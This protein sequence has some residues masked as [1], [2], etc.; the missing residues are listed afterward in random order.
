MRGEG[1]NPAPYNKAFVAP[2]LWQ[3]EAQGSKVLTPEGLD[4]WGH[5][6]DV[7]EAFFPVD[8]AEVEACDLASADQVGHPRG[9]GS[10]GHGFIYDPRTDGRAHRRL[11]LEG[12]AQLLGLLPDGGSGIGSGRPAALCAGASRG[13]IVHSQA[14]KPGALRADEVAIREA[15]VSGDG[16][17]VRPAASHSVESVCVR[18]RRL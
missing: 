10:R 5:E 15:G 12:P 6:R 13:R 17:P 7:V 9:S 8:L 3:R 18:G 11:G 16:D 4:V 2:A 1:V 14:R